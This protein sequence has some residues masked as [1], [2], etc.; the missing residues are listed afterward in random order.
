MHKVHGKR[1][2]QHVDLVLSFYL[3]VGS[4][5]VTLVVKPT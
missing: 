1:R 3:Y 2:G 4:E 5:N